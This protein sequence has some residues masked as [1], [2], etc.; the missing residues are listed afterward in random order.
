M[1]ISW[2]RSAPS[3]AVRSVPPAWTAATVFGRMARTAVADTLSMWTLR[4]SG[5]IGLSLQRGFRPITA[6]DPA[7]TCTELHT[8]LPKSSLSFIRWIPLQPQHRAVQQRNLVLWQYCIT[9]PMD[10]YGLPISQIWSCKTVAVLRGTL[11]ILFNHY[12]Y[13]FILIVNYYRGG[14]HLTMT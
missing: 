12:I 3:W 6:T 4:K 2:S 8:N 5:K 9:T 10:N 11:K 7:R 1:S 13:L 14:P